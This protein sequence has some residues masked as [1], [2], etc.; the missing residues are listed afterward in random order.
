MKKL[1][2]MTSIAVLSVLVIAFSAGIA[3]GSLGGVAGKYKDG[4]GSCHGAAESPLGASVVIDNSEPTN[5]GAPSHMSPG[6]RRTFAVA[7]AAAPPG[8]VGG[9]DAA[10]E[11][12]NGSKA[13]T[14]YGGINTRTY[15]GNQE[16]IHN[17]T[18]AVTGRVFTFDWQAPTTPGTYTLYVVTLAGNGNGGPDNNLPAGVG[19][20]WFKYRG[21]DGTEGYKI[22]VQ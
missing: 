9:I 5:N 14:M 4:C 12:S 17:A 3:T 7:L 1:I 6:E 22:V 11:A 15:Y 2:I 13:G 16:I 10:V 21:A 18:K 19:D 20:A 8:P